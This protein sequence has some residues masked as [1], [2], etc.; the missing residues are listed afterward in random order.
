MEGEFFLL[1]E[2]S[3]SIIF[4]LILLS[5]TLG[6]E[7]KLCILF[8]TLHILKPLYRWSPNYIS[9]L[10]LYGEDNGVIWDVAVNTSET[11]ERMYTVGLFDAASKTS[12]I[13]LCSVAKFD[14]TNFEKVCWKWRWCTV[15]LLIIRK[16]WRRSLLTWWRYWSN[17]NKN[18]RDW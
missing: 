17:N 5:M 11:Y 12:Q 9:Q 3:P 1:P 15:V 7:C 2:I 8:R 18:S 10:F 13:Q 6:L 14:G 4:N 16:G